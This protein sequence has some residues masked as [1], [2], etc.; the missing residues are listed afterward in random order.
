MQTTRGL[1]TYQ[2]FQ[3]DNN[4][5]YSS[6]CG[7]RFETIKSITVKKTPTMKPMHVNP[8]SKNSKHAQAMSEH[9]IQYDD[10]LKPS[11]VTANRAE[12]I[13]REKQKTQPTELM[14]QQ[15][16][17]TRLQ[18]QSHQNQSQGQIATMSQ[19]QRQLQAQQIVQHQQQH[20]TVVGP[21]SGAAQQQQP[22]VVSTSGING[23]VVL[24]QSLSSNLMSAMSL[25]GTIVSTAATAIVTSSTSIAT[26]ATATILSGVRSAV[27]NQGAPTSCRTAFTLQDLQ[28][29]TGT[30]Q[31]TVVSVAS[32]T[33]LQT[34]KL[35][36]SLTSQTTQQR[37]KLK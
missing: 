5:K 25:S 29:R 1:G 18:V 14:Q 20:V 8:A 13:Q 11:Q 17:Q 31:A 35:T 34:A 33:H 28:S 2:M 27:T 15:Q 16:Q 32:L 26:T 10:P 22:V 37:G 19:L 36:A 21:G 30:T 3:Q 4:S 23:K 6:L 12:R 9:G 24:N 7:T